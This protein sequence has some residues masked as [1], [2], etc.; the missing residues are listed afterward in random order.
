MRFHK[1]WLKAVRESKVCV[2]IE[3]IQTITCIDQ[4]DY[5]VQEIPED[6][7]NWYLFWYQFE[8]LV[9]VLVSL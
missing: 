4:I 1:E 2:N 8:I 9:F 5:S 3:C 6:S 7:W